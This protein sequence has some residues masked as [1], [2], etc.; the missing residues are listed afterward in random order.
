MYTSVEI[1]EVCSM[2]IPE[3]TRFVFD[4]DHTGTE[5]DFL[6]SDTQYRMLSQAFSSPSPSIKNLTEL[7]V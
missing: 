1:Y 6:P 4:I 7:F 2:K 3:S 5:G